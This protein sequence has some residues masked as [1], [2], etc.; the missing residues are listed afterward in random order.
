MDWT[1]IKV[2][3][4]EAGNTF[5]VVRP[6]FVLGL[7]GD[8]TLNA[9][10]EAILDWWL[11]Q[12]PKEA[13]LFYLSSKAHQFREV[14]PRTLQR[15]RAS[16]KKLKDEEQFYMFKNAP[17]FAT[18]SHSL[19]LRMG[20]EPDDEAVN[21]LYAAFP[22]D[23]AATVGADRVVEGMREL[24]D[25]FPFR[26]ASAGFGFDLMWG[27]EWEQG[28]MPRIMAAARRFLALDV[29]DRNLEATMVDRVKSAAWLTYLHKDLFDAAGGAKRAREV[30]DE[31]VVEIPTARG[32]LLR[33][34]NDPPVGDSNRGAP[35]LESLRK[36]NRFIAP[37]RE[38]A[39]VSTNL[40][41]IS[42][43]DADAWFSRL[44][45]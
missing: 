35:D 12:L 10:G 33:A 27:R 24:M 37:I 16:L 26:H 7:Y 38:T 19:E 20:I 29:R 43:P 21:M 11:G 44:D 4:T 17:E 5:V 32:V 8:H 34:G 15:I 25:R 42:P 1:E 40:F 22:V 18:G 30:L 45:P 14:N 36:V 31:G 9:H 28:G 41:R 39:W 3:A 6:A 23:H 2:T 13:A